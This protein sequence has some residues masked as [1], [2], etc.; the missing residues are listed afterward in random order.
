MKNKAKIIFHIDLNAFYASVSAINDPYLKDKVFVVGGSAVTS[1]GVITTASYKARALGIK[2]AMPISEAIK[3]YPKVLVVPVN[4]KEYKKYSN[5]FIKFL[6]SYTDRVLVAS[7]D[8]AYLDV[9]EITKD[10]HPLDL[11]KQM[12]QKL[13]EKYELPSSI[14]I[15]PTLYLAKMASDLKKPMGITV[16]RKRDIPKMILPLPIKELH[17][18]GIKTY[19]YLE[20]QGI[21][22]IGDFA[23]KE[24]KELILNYMTEENYQKFINSILGNSSNNVDPSKYDIPKSISNETTFSYDIDSY[25]LLLEELSS[26]YEVIFKRLIK[27]NLLAKTITIKLRDTNFKTITRSKSLNDYS[28]DYN[29]FKDMMEE[30]FYDNYN[31]K[32]LRLVGV[33]YNNIILA[34][35]YEQ[36]YN[37]FTYQKILNNETWYNINGNEELWWIITII[38]KN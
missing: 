15:A 31:N 17:G 24:N 3:I 5:L 29:T 33:G 32:P 1:R 28:S 11:A 34:K 2:S 27:E 7:I 36:D 8:E 35:E 22:T 14:G 30:L 18:L 16:L 6:R 38:W 26:L 25:D 21:K 37:L 4:H 23:R 13:Y 19:P 12:Q 10:I 20:K 9:T